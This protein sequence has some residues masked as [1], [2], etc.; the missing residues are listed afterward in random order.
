M[1]V[2]MRL[3]K[4]IPCDMRFL[5]RKNTMVFIIRQLQGLALCGTHKPIRGASRRHP[6]RRDPYKAKP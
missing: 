4:A 3:L 1:D 2:F 5:N 6:C